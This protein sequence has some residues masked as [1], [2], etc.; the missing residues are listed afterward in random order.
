MTFDFIIKHDGKKVQKA[1]VNDLSDFDP[2]LA[3][4]KEKFG[5]RKKGRRCN[6]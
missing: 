4:L 6:G 1:K 2:I 3:G 5:Y